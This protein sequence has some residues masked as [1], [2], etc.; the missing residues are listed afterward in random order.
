M[1]RLVMT[2][3]QLN[4]YVRSRLEED[5][6]LS[7]VFISGEITDLKQN[8]SS[9]HVYFTLKDGAAALKCICY[10]STLP[11]IKLPLSNGISVVCQ[12]S[13]TLYERDGA[14]QLR[15]IGIKADGVGSAALEAERL[16]EKL[17]TEGIFSQERKRP[18]PKYPLKIAVVTAPS[19][20]AFADI[21]NT[22]S[23]RWPLC[24]IKLFPSAVQGA[25]APLELLAALEAAYLDKDI[26]LLIIGRGGG[27]SEELSAFND[28]Q[29]VR[30]LARAPFP[31]VSAVGHE[32]DYSLTDLAADLRAA[33]PTAAAELATPDSAE[34][35]A[36]I[37]LRRERISALTSK[38]LE[39]DS[40]RLASLMR[41]SVLTDRAYFI[42]HAE[43][44]TEESRRRLTAAFSGKLE[45]AGL[46]L[47]KRLAALD[48]LSPL[49]TL[50]RGYAA[51][52]AEGRAVCSV[53]ELA[54]GDSISVIM[55]DGELSCKITAKR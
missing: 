30:A 37:R 18:L 9:G 24:E 33:T 4:R 21:Y 23:R 55:S 5:P 35:A 15:V 48:S 11:Y 31:T 7:S 10:A 45:R 54:V 40:L 27:S 16:K 20:A 13:V 52:A 19:G 3:S 46:E 43:A 47:G 25:R 42:K 49:K 50:S 36:G 53:S 14:Y 26:E 41:S 6:R 32:T 39:A 17:R 29:L 1:N 34:L 51:V 44:V 28:E 38:K 2:V 12:G 8:P 22:I